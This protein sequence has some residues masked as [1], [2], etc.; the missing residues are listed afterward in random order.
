M[1][2]WV[3]NG[4]DCELAKQDRVS[5]TRQLTQ[6]LASQYDAMLFKG[7]GL[8][9]LLDGNQLCVYNPSILR[10]IDKTLAKAGEIGSK[11]RRKLDGMVGIL[12]DRR[13]I[14]AEIS[15]KYHNGEPEFLTIKWKRGGTVHNVYPSQIDFL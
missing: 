8:R 1:N 4:Y 7:M 6:V 9:R 3:S 12:M 10:R 5:A 14:D 15:T 2:W 13:S 11:V